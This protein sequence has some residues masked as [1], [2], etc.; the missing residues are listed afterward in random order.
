MPYKRK[1]Q[2]Y[3][4]YYKKNRAGKSSLPRRSFQSRVKRVLLK[5]AETKYF[6]IAD[7]NVELYHNSGA[8]ALSYASISQLANP[9]ADIVK[10]TGRMN[11]IGDKILP[12]GMSLK[13]WLANK[14]DRPN[15]QYRVIVYRATKTVT[16][17]ITTYSTLP[18][19][20]ADQGST[21]NKLLLPI[22]NEAGFRALYDKI[23]KPRTGWGWKGGT[24]NSREFSMCLKLWIKRKGARQ[25]VFDQDGA[26][27]TNNPIYVA[28]IPYEQY[29]T[30]T[31][32]NIASLSVYARLY[33]KD[34]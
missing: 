27:I 25:I 2:K 29:S 21:G 26:Y 32:D 22:D 23:V 18:F 8:G 13:F 6:D 12:R 3:K 33:Y 11:R 16:G 19:Q 30:L 15:V 14:A 17:A 20:V 5:T 1:Y 34:V 28:V 10:G 31:A 24:A 4:K 9:W 7:E